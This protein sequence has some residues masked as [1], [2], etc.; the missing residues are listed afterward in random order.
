MAAAEQVAEHVGATG[1]KQV[2]TAT[3]QLSRATKQVAEQGGGTG[4]EQ[5]GG[6]ARQVVDHRSLA[7]IIGIS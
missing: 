1:I 4:T 3:G 7:G 2:V 5:A 6:A